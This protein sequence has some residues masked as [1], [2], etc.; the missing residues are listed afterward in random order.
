VVHTLVVPG[1]VS[2]AITLFQVNGILQYVDAQGN[3]TGHDDVFT[4]I[5]LCRKHFTA[6]GLGADYVQRFIR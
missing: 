4:K 5:E 1:D 6:V 3:P 2:E